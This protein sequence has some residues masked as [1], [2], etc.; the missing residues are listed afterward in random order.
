MSYLLINKFKL[1]TASSF[2][3]LIKNMQFLIKGTKEVSKPRVH[4]N[5]QTDRNKDSDIIPILTLCLTPN[6]G[7]IIHS[8][9]VSFR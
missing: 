9:Q 5:P 3:N 6:C 4:T 8:A 2:S 7:E 1:A